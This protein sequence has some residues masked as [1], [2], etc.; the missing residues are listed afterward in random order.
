MKKALYAGLMVLCVVS[1]AAPSLAKGKPHQQGRQNRPNVER[2]A[3]P[4]T[5]DFNQTLA[6]PTAGLPTSQSSRP[7]RSNRGGQLR[8]RDRAAYVHHLNDLAKQQRNAARPNNQSNS[9]LQQAPVLPQQGLPSTNTAPQ[10]ID[11]GTSSRTRIQ[12]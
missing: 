4:D 2:S 11:F 5:E 9:C 8:G 6:C 1:L 3:E 12:Q 10:E 7:E